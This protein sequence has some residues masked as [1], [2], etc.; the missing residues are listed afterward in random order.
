MPADLERA[1]YVPPY[2]CNVTR[3]GGGHEVL[4][5]LTVQRR[6]EEIAPVVRREAT[7]TLRDRAIGHQLRQTRFIHLIRPP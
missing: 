2:A 3:G 1:V 5:A 6:T 7:P 4:G